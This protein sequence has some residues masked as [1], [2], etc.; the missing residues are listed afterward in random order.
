MEKSLKFGFRASNNEAKYEALISGLRAVKQLGAEE[1]KIFSDS[2]LVV[3]QIEGSF[4]ARDSC[5]Q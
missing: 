1:V 5:M 4:E 2:K 3:S